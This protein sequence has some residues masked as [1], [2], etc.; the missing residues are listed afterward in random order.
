VKRKKSKE[1]IKKIR[2]E[3]TWE[4]ERNL[5]MVGI[6]IRRKADVDKL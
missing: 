5:S 1:A 3:R 4:K 6:R 2:E